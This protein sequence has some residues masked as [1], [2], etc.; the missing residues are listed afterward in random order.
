MQ[1]ASRFLLAW[2]ICY[3][4]PS[5]AR[6]PALTSMLI[7]HS[8]T[9]IIRYGYFALTLSG[10]NPGILSWLRYNT[11]YVLYPLGISSECWLVY[12][13]I[14]LAKRVNPVYEYVLYGILA[15]YVPGSNI[16][17]RHMMRQRRKVMKGKSTK[18][19]Q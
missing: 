12:K 19:E 17:Y 15:I 3:P 6:S 16:L 7:A 4:F 10:R 13:A 18:K 14:P 5:V 2:G 1:V 9:E 8:V 11:F